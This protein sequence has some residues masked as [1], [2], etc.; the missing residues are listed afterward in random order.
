[1]SEQLPLPLA[2]C[3]VWAVDGPIKDIA[4]STTAAT[5]AKMRNMEILPLNLLNMPSNDATKRKRLEYKS[6]KEGLL[7]LKIATRLQWKAAVADS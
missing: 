7:R 5:L 1:M 3:C 6:Y 2:F 4:I